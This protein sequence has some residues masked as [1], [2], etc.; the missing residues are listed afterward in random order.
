LASGAQQL[1]RAAEVVGQFGEGAGRAEHPEPPAE[2]IRQRV[3][4]T[5]V[6]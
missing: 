2:R 4:I 5:G 3:L 1:H 6:Q